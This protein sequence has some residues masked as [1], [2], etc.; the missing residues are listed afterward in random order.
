MNRFMRW[1]QH[2]AARRAARHAAEIAGKAQEATERAD[3]TIRDIRDLL[4]Q[5]QAFTEELRRR[6]DE[7]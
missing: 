3:A 5:L 2:I 6:A 1:Q 7:S 4:P